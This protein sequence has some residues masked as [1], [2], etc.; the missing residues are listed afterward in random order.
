M[1][2]WVAMM[3]LHQ[4]LFA[5]CGKRLHVAFEHRLERLRVF[6]SGCC[7]AI[8]LT[9]SSAKASWMYIGCSTHSVPSLSNTAMRS[10]SGHEIGR[11]FLG[12]LLDERDDRRLRRG[13]VPG[14]QGIGRCGR[15]DG[16]QGA[17]HQQAGKLMRWRGLFS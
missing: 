1:P 13:V 17:E 15:R 10:G 6:H 8:A 12:H 11:A 9:R 2:A 3:S 5:G 14:R 16:E 7:G 4:A